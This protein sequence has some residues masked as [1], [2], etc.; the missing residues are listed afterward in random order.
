MIVIN[1][2]VTIIINFVVNLW[3]FYFCVECI[4]SFKSFNKCFAWFWA[5]LLRDKMT[6][7]EIPSPNEMRIDCDSRVMY[8][9][10]WSMTSNTCVR[11]MGHHVVMETEADI[12]KCQFLF[13]VRGVQQAST[14]ASTCVCVCVCNCLAT[15]VLNMYIG[16]YQPQDECNVTSF[17]SRNVIT[18][19]KDTFNKYKKCSSMQHNYLWARG[20]LS[21]PM[22]RE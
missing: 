12:P 9:W 21:R 15:K 11:E 14:A 18:V 2:N 8:I 4:A 7:D 6:F 3:I 5:T 1:R 19:K 13:W 16:G 17:G 10:L 20:L 22:Y